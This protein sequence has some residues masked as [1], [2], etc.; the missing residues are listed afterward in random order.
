MSDSTA[1]WTALE[2]LILVQAVYKHGEDSWTQVSK[3][4]RTHPALA[5]PMEFFTPRNCEKH[6]QALVAEVVGTTVPVVGTVAPEM[7]PMAQV[8]R[9][10]HIQRI[11]E[12]KALLREDE[13]EFRKILHEMDDIRTG[14]WDERLKAEWKETH[15]VGVATADAPAGSGDQASVQAASASE[16]GHTVPEPAEESA[17]SSDPLPAIPATPTRAEPKRRGRK[18]STAKPPLAP[19]NVSPVVVP[20]DVD[21]PP[22]A[23]ATTPK[24]GSAASPVAPS[25]RSANLK[26]EEP[27]PAS[28]QGKDLAPSPTKKSFAGRRGSI[29]QS[30]KATNDSSDPLDVDSGAE[31]SDG[32]RKKSLKSDPALQIWRKTVYFILT[33]I[34]DHRYGNVFATPVKDDNYHAVV[35]QSMSIDAVRARVRRGITTT[36]AQFHRDLLLMF[37]NAIMYNN[38]DSEVYSMAQ[39]MK[40]FVDAEIVNLHKYGTDPMRERSVDLGGQERRG[41]D[42]SA[43]DG[44]PGA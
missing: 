11:E 38:E 40:D 24:K 36:T 4:L 32:E 35:K 1:G 20:V 41:S 27:T 13:E 8:A 26:D 3:L 44:G 15:P 5:R 33:K 25:P 42:E 22:S 14:K 9:K 30:R 43:G 18:P 23:N 10:L 31:N 21:R 29:A 16:E 7:M 12:I 39:E 19:L 6:F 2:S 28:A 17:E 34:A 37:T